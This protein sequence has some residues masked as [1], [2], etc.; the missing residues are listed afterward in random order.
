MHPQDIDPVIEI[1]SEGP[2]GHLFF[3]VPVGSRDDPD[4]GMDRAISSHTLERFILEHL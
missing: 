3:E 2:G 4:I 1:L